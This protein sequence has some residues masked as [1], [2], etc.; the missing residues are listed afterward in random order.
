[1]VQ[2]LYDA[3]PNQN[4]CVKLIWSA[5]AGLTHGVSESSGGIPSHDI[6]IA[7]RGGAGRAT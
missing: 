6:M 4:V 3:K 2:W 7:T 1:M 5:A